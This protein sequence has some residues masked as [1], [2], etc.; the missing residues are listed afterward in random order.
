MLS[1]NSES[2]KVKQLSLIVFN[3]C[4]LGKGSSHKGSSASDQIKTASWWVSSTKPLDRLHNDRSIGIGALKELQPYSDPSSGS[5]AAG[6]HC[7]CRLLFSK[8]TVELTRENGNRANKIAINLAFHTEIQP[9]SLNECSSDCCKCLVHFQN[10]EKKND[11]NHFFWCSHCFYRGD[12]FQ[13]SLVFLFADITSIQGLLN[14][15][16]LWWLQQEGMLHGAEIK[17]ESSSL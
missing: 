14:A 12:G 6:S 5:Q 7:D 15:T 3:K 16:I 8:V 2:C 4:C 13:R 17:S 9:F 1:T 10:P 11:S